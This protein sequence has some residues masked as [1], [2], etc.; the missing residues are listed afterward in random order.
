MAPF[1]EQFTRHGRRR[2]VLA[3]TLPIVPASGN[4]GYQGGQ[5]GTVNLIG[6]GG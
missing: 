5:D 4:Q 6:Y 3:S 2:I 1:D